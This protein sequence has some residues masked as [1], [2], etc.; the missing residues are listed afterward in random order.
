MTIVSQQP[1][2]EYPK[3]SLEKRTSFDAIT[4][5]DTLVGPLGRCVGANNHVVAIHFLRL[6]Y[7]LYLHTYIWFFCYDAHVMIL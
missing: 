7:G 1:I 6:R 3:Q 4:C 5:I 2:P